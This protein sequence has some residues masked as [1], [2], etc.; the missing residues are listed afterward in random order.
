MLMS[1]H[2]LD[3]LPMTT[4]VLSQ[5]DHVWRIVKYGEELGEPLIQCRSEDEAVAAI[6]E[7]AREQRP[8]QIIR[9]AIS[10]DSRI[11]AHFD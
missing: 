3:L 4:F 7:L 8:S 2:W 6:M 1:S 11:I 9:I 5:G 10:G